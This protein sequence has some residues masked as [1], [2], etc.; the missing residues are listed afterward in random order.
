VVRKEKD[1]KRRRRRM[2][3]DYFKVL[4]VFYRVRVIGY[5]FTGKDIG[6]C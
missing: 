4:V 6:Y 5:I 2:A 1:K 3:T